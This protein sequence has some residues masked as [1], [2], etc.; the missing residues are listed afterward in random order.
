M[1]AR[2]LRQRLILGAGLWLALALGVGGVVLGLAFRDAAEHG[3]HER[4]DAYLRALSA[5]VEINADGSVA[6]GKP[7]GDPRFEQAY[8]G[9]YWQVSDGAEVRARSRSLWDFALPVGGP[10]AA[11][12]MHAR[13]DTGPRGESL[14]VVERDL[15]F[16][17][18]IRPL[19]LSVA[20]NRREVEAEVARFDLLLALALGGLGL[21][22]IIAIAL[23]V[24]YGLRPLARLT[25]ELEEVRVSGGRIGEAYPGEVAP[26]VLAMN[27]VLDHDAR[28]IERARAHVGNLAH[29]LKTPLAVLEAELA[30]PSPDHGVLG[31]QLDRLNRLVDI[32]LGRARAEAVSAEPARAKVAVG[33]VAN[34]IAA[35]LRKI[36]AERG[37]SLSVDCAPGARFPGNGDDLAEILGNLM[38]NACKWA[39]SQVRITAD[40]VSLTVEDDGPGLTPAQAETATRRGLRLDESAPGSGL[41]LAIV[42]DLAGMMGL[43]VRFGRSDL[44]GLCV[45]VAFPAARL[46]PT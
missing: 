20:A 6:V 27:Q 8:S 43:D 4:L 18:G 1:P 13:R 24:G 16:P 34:D 3:F 30:S 37:L 7:V 10:V 42:A 23:Q 44:G 35:A 22:L 5:V 46:P 19:H 2:S 39:S 28:L 26:L 21:G 14:A 33:E 12:Q 45:R 41:G 25:G 38:D 17:D 15:L 40:T 36:Y 31:D 11:G 9:W 32:H 29:G